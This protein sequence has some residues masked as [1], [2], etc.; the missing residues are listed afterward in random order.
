MKAK[1]IGILVLEV[2]IP[3]RQGAWRSPHGTDWA[4][5]DL[6]D[7]DVG[8]MVAVLEDG[9]GVVYGVAPRGAVG[10]AVGDLVVAEV[11]RVVVDEGVDALA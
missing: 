8:P 10:E 7:A 11:E 2:R 9:V 1:P 4:R 5:F 3:S 6:E